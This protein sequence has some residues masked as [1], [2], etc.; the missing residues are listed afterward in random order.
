VALPSE[1]YDQVA[2]AMVWEGAPLVTNVQIIGIAS[3]D[4]A[5]AVAANDRRDPKLAEAI[6]SFDEVKDALKKSPDAVRTPAVR[7]KLASVLEM[8]PKHFSAKLLAL[9]AENKQPKKLTAGAST[10]YLA[11][12]VSSVMPVLAER[13]KAMAKSHG[14]SQAPAAQIEEGL[15]S[16]AKVRRLAAPE[17]LPLVE[18]WGDFMKTAYDVQTGRA[19]AKSLEAKA[20][21][22]EDAM[23]RHNTNQALMEK[24][25]HEGI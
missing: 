7:E 25:L 12:A 20:Q 19:A 14:K 11:Q 15:R 8:A 10:Y 18:A 9:T 23:A 6:K 1:N 5:V 24:M 21:T 3:L 17:I 13:S 2:D 4:D 22:L 16:L